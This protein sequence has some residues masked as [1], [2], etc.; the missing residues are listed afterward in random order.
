M[1]RR[2]DS[3]RTSA[4]AAGMAV[5]GLACIGL[6]V[7]TL[8]GAD[9]PERAAPMQRQAA[10]PPSAP[11]VRESAVNSGVN[12][13][14]GP[15]AIEPRVAEPS[16]TAVRTEAGGFYPL[17]VGRYWVYRY[18]DASSGII[19]EVERRIERRE[20]RPDV[21]LFY[22]NDGT[23]AYSRDGKVYEMAPAGGV[24]VIPVA[25]GHDPFVYR[26]QGLHIEKSIG[27]V[28]TTMV[29]QGRRYESCHSVVS[30]LRRV[31]QSA[32][33]TASFSTYYA[34]GVGLIGREQLSGG[35]VGGPAR[36]SSVLQSYG[37]NRL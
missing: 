36:S 18:E 33:Q 22:F 2:P 34:R 12:P 14:A 28:D 29:W 26:S 37:I 7:S 1:G 35:D 21:E 4:I 17:E 27:A 6:A 10:A 9:E 11:T 16:A 8:I 32:D 30:R 20:I 3:A 19:T 24:N 15:I 5:S 13:G 31:D 23:M 25:V